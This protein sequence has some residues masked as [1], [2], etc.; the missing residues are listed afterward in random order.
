MESV[1]AEVANFQ[2]L[3]MQ[4]S[5]ESDSKKRSQLEASLTA[6]LNSQKIII[7][8]QRLLPDSNYAGNMAIIDIF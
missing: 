3:L 6:T 5:S 7:I 1:D 4:I 2:K 8:L